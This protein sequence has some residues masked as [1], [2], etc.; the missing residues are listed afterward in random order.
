MTVQDGEFDLHLWIP[1]RGHGPGLLLLQ[2]IH[3]VGDY[4]RAVAEDLAGLGYVVGAPDLFWRLERNWTADHGEEGLSRALAMGGRFDVA[5]GV[6]D[7]AAAFETLASLPEV[8][9]GTGVVGFC[10]GGSLAYVLAARTTPSVVLSFYGSAVP[11][12]LD[13][14]DRITS[15]VQFH[16]GGR[17]EFIPREKVAAVERAVAGRPG[18]EIHVQESAGH[19]F[20][21]FKSARFHDAEAART[22]WPLATGFLAR[23]LPAA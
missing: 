1:A 9:G 12:S 21:N 14:L 5:T 8:A 11:D 10:L 18:M 3:G 15:P 22:A 16:F 17:D 7:S 20:H 2:E 19:A 4:I 13:L 6:D 23:H